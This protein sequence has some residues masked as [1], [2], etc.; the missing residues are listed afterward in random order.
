MV[1]NFILKIIVM[2]SFGLKE[3][4]GYKV[5]L[6]QRE[7][8]VILSQRTGGVSQRMGGV[9]LSQREGGVFAEEGR[10]YHRGRE[11]FS[12]RMGGFI[13]EGGRGFAEEWREPRAW[14]R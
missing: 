2:L 5:L 10:F 3:E 4:G 1:Y 6:S 8:R 11:G 9:I 12:Q 14:G 13:T 7:G